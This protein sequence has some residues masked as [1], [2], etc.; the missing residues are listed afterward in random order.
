M[1]RYLGADWLSMREVQREL[2]LCMD[3]CERFVDEGRLSAVWLKCPAHS[4]V[5]RSWERCY[6]SR[7]QVEE[8][9][10][11]FRALDAAYLDW[12]EKGC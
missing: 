7:R 5:V 3:D 11:R 1:R 2:G 4:A 8:L 6:V 12:E 9:A 10:L